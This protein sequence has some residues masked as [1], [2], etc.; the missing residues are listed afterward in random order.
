MLINDYT[1]FDFRNVNDLED[2]ITSD[3]IGDL[4]TVGRAYNKVYDIRL[5][6]L[7]LFHYQRW[8]HDRIPLAIIFNAND[9]YGCYNGIN[10]HYLHPDVR[11]RF[12]IMLYETGRINK[13]FTNV[14]LNYDFIKEFFGDA[15]I[16]FRRYKPFAIQYLRHVPLKSFISEHMRHAGIMDPLFQAQMHERTAQVL[17]AGKYKKY[18]KGR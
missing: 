10:L 6:H 3:T 16:C 7:Y 17:A 13:K 9:E 8:K 18:S 11:L 4:R 14:R 1:E 15:S 12:L 2:S 5:G